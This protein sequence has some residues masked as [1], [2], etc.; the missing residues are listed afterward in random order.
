M[1]VRYRDYGVYA[2]GVYGVYA[3][4]VSTMGCTL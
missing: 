1:G 3:I 2:I 4:E